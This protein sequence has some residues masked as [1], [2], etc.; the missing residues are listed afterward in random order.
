MHPVVP[1]EVMA[2]VW[3]HLRARDARPRP[4]L[5]EGRG[6]LRIVNQDDSADL[7]LYDEIGFWGIPATMVVEQLLDITSPAVTV[8]INSPGGDVFDGIAIY[9]ALRDHHATVTV[10]V[11]ALAAS[12]ASLIAMAGDEIHM[13]RGSQM[14]IHDASGVA[15]GNA[16]TMREMMNLLDRVSDTIAGIYAVRAGGDVGG[17]RE[18]MRAE[19]WYS[20]N[21]AVSAGLADDLDKTVPDEDAAPVAARFD[22]ALTSFLYAGRGQAPTPGTAPV[23]D[24]TGGGRRVPDPD[25]LADLPGTAPGS[26]PDPGPDPYRLLSAALDVLVSSTKEAV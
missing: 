1:A 3:A 9:N 14:M 10:R 6:R 21:E 26:G 13:N 11:D 8:H 19:T 20:A 15:M 22:L 5:P 12:A 25:Q 23:R 2:R 7:Y 4:T 24:A 16:A 18:L 17:W